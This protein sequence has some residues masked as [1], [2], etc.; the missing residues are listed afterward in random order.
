M[1]VTDW[2][3]E[4]AE[5]MGLVTVGID[6][7]QYK[8]IVE[9]LIGN[10]PTTAESILKRSINS[11]TKKVGKELGTLAQERY[12][13]K[14]KRFSSE[15]HY[16]MAGEKDLSAEIV[17]RGEALAASY[18]QT[19]PS[20]PDRPT[21]QGSKAVRLSVLK[22]ESPGT[23]THPGT[24]LTAF[25]TQFA[26]GH[27]AVVQRKPPKTYTGS[28]WAQRQQ[29]HA[30][31]Y[32]GTGLLDKTRIRQFFGPAVPKMLEKTGITQQYIDD[33]YTKI[34][35]Y[36]EDYILMYLERERY[37]FQKNGGGK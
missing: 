9:D 3:T 36:L 18:F 14:K 6:A 13:V 24:G 4:N 16:H 21:M 22:S 19:T 10:L 25:L 31:F 23:I 1:S 30:G 12:R 28:G 15:I 5:N 32:K 8:A 17:A 26:S 33:N 37:F 34:Q 11:T 2:V 27:V 7:E 35:G 20:K 29:K